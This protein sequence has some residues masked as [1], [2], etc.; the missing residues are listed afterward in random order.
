[1]IWN[2]PGSFRASSPLPRG[3]RKRH[4][5]S[6]SRLPFSVEN[7][8]VVQ[9]VPWSKSRCDRRVHPRADTGSNVSTKAER[10]PRVMI[11]T[12]DTPDPDQSWQRPLLLS[13]SS[14]CLDTQRRANFV[15]PVP[16]SISGHS[17]PP[18]LGVEQPTAPPWKMKRPLHHARVFQ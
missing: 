12:A 18:P 15:S 13:G 5:S 7:P 9:Q 1:M 2:P 17:Q 16:R 8:K 3:T 10:R 6:P 14:A 11:D 4:V